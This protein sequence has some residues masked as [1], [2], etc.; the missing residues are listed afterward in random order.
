MPHAHAGVAGPPHTCASPCR[1]ATGRD[2]GRHAGQRCAVATPRGRRPTERTPTPRVRR[3][4]H[5]RRPQLQENL[6]QRAAVGDLAR[7]RVPRADDHR[8]DLPRRSTLAS[9]SRSL[10]SALTLCL[11]VFALTFPGRNRFRDNLL[12]AGRRHRHRRGSCCWPSWR[13]AATPRAAC[14]TSRTTCCSPGRS[15]RRCCSGSRCGSARRVAAPPRRAAARR[16][17]RPSSSAPAPLGVKVAR[18]WPKADDQGVDFVGY[19]DDRTDDRVARRGRHERLGTLNDVA[20]YVT[21]ARHQGGLH[22]AAA[23]LAAAHRRAARA[24][25]GHHRVAVLRAR[26][27]RHQHH[28]GPA[29]GHERRAGRRHLRDAVHRHQRAGQAAS[30][31]SCSRR[32]SWC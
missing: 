6:L 29:A 9:T 8:A 27:V 25:A 17:A 1:R 7:R 3:L 32:S 20:P 22:H 2:Y 4:P 16:A 31:T 14:T 23:R 15:S 28:P 24:G 19:F 12:A 13:C 11:L 10:R 18:R 30:A 5:V 26:R 21:R